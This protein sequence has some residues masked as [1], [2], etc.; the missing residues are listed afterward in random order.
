[1][2]AL[3]MAWKTLQVLF[4]PKNVTLLGLLSAAFL[5]VAT[6]DLPPQAELEQLIPTGELE[7]EDPAQ[8]NDCYRKLWATYQFRLARYRLDH[9]TI[10]YVTATLR[11]DGEI[12]FVF[13]NDR[14][15]SQKLRT[16]K[17]IDKLWLGAFSVDPD[18][19]E[20]FRY[21]SIQGDKETIQPETWKIYWV[22]FL[23]KAC[24]PAMKDRFLANTR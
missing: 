2:F 10:P 9:G 23:Q 13:L 16:K 18:T 19:G 3:L 12:F 5:T 21:G 6:P 11:Q 8:M 24:P 7:N 15:D 20:C 4:L 22:E 1:M 14:E 17:A